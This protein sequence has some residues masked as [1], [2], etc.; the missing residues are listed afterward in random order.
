MMSLG[1]CYGRHFCCGIHRFSHGIK[2]TASCDGKEKNPFCFCFLFSFIMIRYIFMFSAA[3]MIRR[4]KQ[5]YFQPWYAIF[6]KG[7]SPIRFHITC[8]DR[9]AVL[10][11]TSYPHFTL[12]G[13]W[14]S[15]KKNKNIFLL[16]CRWCRVL[17]LSLIP[18]F[19]K[20]PK[21]HLT[22]QLNRLQS[23]HIASANRPETPYFMHSESLVRLW[24]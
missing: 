4:G 13:K 14:G 7:Q 2:T 16:S 22:C 9:A 1:I 17:R 5:E 18:K 11:K 21:S 19:R 6:C 8:Y 3:K 12:F 20:R 23:G 24:A 10:L 15:R